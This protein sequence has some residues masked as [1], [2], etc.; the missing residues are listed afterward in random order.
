VAQKRTAEFFLSLYDWRIALDY[1]N[2][3]KMDADYIDMP[4]TYVITDESG[5]VLDATYDGGA[6]FATSTDAYYWGEWLDENTFIDHHITATLYAPPLGQLN[7]DSWLELGVDAVGIWHLHRWKNLSFGI[8]CWLLTLVVLIYLYHAAGR[9][10]GE[11]NPRCNALD[12]IPFDLFTGAYAGIGILLLLLLKELSYGPDVV[13]LISL[14][15]FAVCVVILLFSYTMSIATRIKTHTLWRNTLIGYLLR[16]ILAGC[17]AVGR[18]L[19]ALWQALLP[20]RR[21]LLAAMIWLHG[22][23]S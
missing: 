19:P 22:L 10:P 16:G 23:F 4:Y 18:H 17:R 9:H 15:V 3:G 12:R 11:E 1:A 21:P 14:V 8:G 20:V 13:F 6:Y 2:D 5:A 7:G